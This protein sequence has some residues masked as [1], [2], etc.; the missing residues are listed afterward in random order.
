MAISTSR[1]ASDLTAILADLPDT[2]AIGAT[3]Y[4]CAATE[5]GSDSAPSDAGIWPDAD[6]EL[7]AAYAAAFVVGAKVVYGTKT[8]RVESVKHSPDGVSS[9]LFCRSLDKPR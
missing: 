2:F 1:M 6:L 3:S 5:A 7:L 4:S 8:Y 9:R